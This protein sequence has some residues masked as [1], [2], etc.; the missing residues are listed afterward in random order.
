MNVAIIPARGGSKRIKNKNV[1][2]FSGNPIMHYSIKAA[3]DSKLFDQVIVSTDSELIANTAKDLGASVPF[4][5]PAE[6]S[7]DHTATAPVITHTLEWL[8]KN[9]FNPEFACC[10]YATAPFVRTTDLIE[11]FKLVKEGKTSS[12]FAVTSFPFPIQRAL[13]ITSDDQ[14]EMFWPEHENTRSQDL[15]EA[16]HDAGQF[17]WI[18][19]QSFIKEPRFYTNESRPVI[20]PR[21]LVQ[22]ID[23]LED[24]ETAEFMYKLLNR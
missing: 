1:K 5:R 14:L 2:M 4:M 13:K 20:L 10:I 23:T 16:Y 8:L 3:I 7:D 21:H 24:W 9:G 18:N 6:L 17:Y 15:P 12:S 19:C 11:G 22:D